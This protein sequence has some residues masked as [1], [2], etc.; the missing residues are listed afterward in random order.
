MNKLMTV[1][2]TVLT[3][4]RGNALDSILSDFKKSINKLDRYMEKQVDKHG[5]NLSKIDKLSEMNNAIDAA[6]VKAAA[7]KD[8]LRSLIKE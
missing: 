4:G 1:L 3:L 2:L 5:K 7:V 6:V 8:N